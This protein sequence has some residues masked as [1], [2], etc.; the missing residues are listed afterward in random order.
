M[1]YSAWLLAFLFS[2]PH[3][4]SAQETVLMLMIEPN[5][6]YS[7]NVGLN[8]FTMDIILDTGA[9]HNF[10]PEEYLR[11]VGAEHT[12]IIGKGELPGGI[13]VEM[14]L[15]RLQSLTIGSCVLRNVMVGGTLAG[16]SVIGLNVLERIGPVTFDFKNQKLSFMCNEQEQRGD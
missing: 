16:L 12:G 2:V 10:M 9:T 4:A 3:M 8:N 11:L 15:Y 13:V 6:T 7:T 5:R 14:P 1:K